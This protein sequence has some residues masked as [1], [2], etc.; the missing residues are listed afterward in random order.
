MGGFSTVLED[1]LLDHVLKTGAYG[2]PADIY[3]ALWVGDPTDTGGGGAEVSGGSY[4]RVICNTWDAASARATE[5]TGAVTF[6]EATGAWGTVTHFAIFDDVAAGNFLAHGTLAASKV[7]GTGDN[8][9][10]AAGDI[11][12][13]VDSGAFSDYLANALLDH[14]FKVAP[15][16]QPAGIYVALCTVT[17]IDANDGSAITEHSGDNYSRKQHDSWD[18]SASGASENTGAITFDQ[19]SAAWGEITDVALCDAST[20]GEVLIYAVLDAAKVIG[21]LDIAEW[22]A[23]AFDVTLT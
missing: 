14:V 1:E 11:D 5:N 2:V 10:F 16:S 9:E 17:I 8:A 13:S 3:V 12:V 22:A 21:N 18:A 19:A 15:Y 23:G 7:I 20:T 6:P 4:A